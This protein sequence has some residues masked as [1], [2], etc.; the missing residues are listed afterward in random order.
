MNC[1]ALEFF[2]VEHET[3]KAI[4]G[5]SVLDFS[6]LPYWAMRLLKEAVDKDPAAKAELLKMHP[7]S[8]YKQLEQMARCRFGG[9]DFHADIQNGV[10]QDGE[11]WDCP[12]RGLCTGEGKICKCIKFNG[13]ELSGQEVKLMRC[14]TTDMTN[15]V[16]AS[17]LLLPM[18]TFH[19]VK[20]KLYQKLGVATKQELTIIAYRLNII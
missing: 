5:G 15:E 6:Q 19:L 18:G 7:D 10:L 14:L 2:V 4:Q 16:I 17:E 3:V 11:Y 12:K 1:G 9:L 20:K 8:E 13:Q